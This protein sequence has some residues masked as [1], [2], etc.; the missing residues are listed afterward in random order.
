MLSVKSAMATLWSVD[1]HA[2]FLIIKSF[3]KFLKTQPI[4]KAQA[5]QMAQKKFIQH[6]IYNHPMFWGPFLLIGNWL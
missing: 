2:T 3:Y 5:L 4:S 6:D 1:D